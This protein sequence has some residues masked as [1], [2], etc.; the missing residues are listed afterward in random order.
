VLGEYL[1]AKPVT[2]HSR[3]AD[4]RPAA[5]LETELAKG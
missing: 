5:E 2:A 1:I 4:A 3:A